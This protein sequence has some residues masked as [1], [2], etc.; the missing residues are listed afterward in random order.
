MDS[1][2]VVVSAHGNSLRAL[3][4]LIKE[5]PDDEIVSLEVPNAVPIVYELDAALKPLGRSWLGTV[6]ASASQIL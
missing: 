1:K 5:I 4:K 2:R 6:P 3:I